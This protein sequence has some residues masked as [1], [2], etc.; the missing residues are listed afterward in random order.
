MKV[1][2]PY[3][4]AGTP[5]ST[6]E[7]RAAWAAESD[8]IKAKYGWRPEHSVPGGEYVPTGQQRGLPG[9][10]GGA[11][12]PSTSTS[13]STTGSG[14]L[15]GST[16]TGG[17]G[18]RTTQPV[19]SRTSSSGASSGRIPAGSRSPSP[20][21]WSGSSS[22]RRSGSGASSVVGAGSGSGWEPRSWN[23]ASTT[24]RRG[25]ADAPYEPGRSAKEVADAY[26]AWEKR[27]GEGKADLREAIE[28]VR[29]HEKS[30]GNPAP[31]LRRVKYS[32]YEA[33]RAY[34]G[35]NRQSGDK[36]RGAWFA[37]IKAMKDETKSLER[38]LA[39]YDEALGRRGAKPGQ[40]P[41]ASA[42]VAV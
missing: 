30:G 15:P 9:Y 36:K 17:G 27:H 38:L 16:G 14:Q 1:L 10:K 32:V 23:P 19:P 6:S 37:E 8:R 4:K 35:E 11:P 21:S 41:E 2:G 18:T 3:L 31:Y 33:V 28:L 22:S 7:I 25:A 34:R 26:N 39:I 13:T 42:T 24:S 29:E 5:G 40:S 12:S 20:Q